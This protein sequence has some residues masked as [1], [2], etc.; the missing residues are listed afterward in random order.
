L[1]SVE[2]HS[3][4]IQERDGANRVLDACKERCPRLGHI[5]ADGSYRGQLVEWVKAEHAWRL[6]MVE[7]LPGQKGLQVLP[8][9]WVVE[10]PFAWL[11]RYR[12][13]AKN[14]C[15]NPAVLA[16]TGA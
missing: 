2:V 3:A 13:L 16:I 6:E 5:W 10:R 12:R 7:K 1:L 9:R 11:G 15:K 8:R 14:L 4:G